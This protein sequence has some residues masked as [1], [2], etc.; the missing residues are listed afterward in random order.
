MLMTPPANEV[1]LFSPTRANTIDTAYKNADKS[2][3]AADKP[4]PLYDEKDE[5]CHH[6][7]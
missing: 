1:P 4:V 5:K 7:F 2:A 3:N 6:L